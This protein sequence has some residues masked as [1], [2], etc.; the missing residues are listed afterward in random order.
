VVTRRSPAGWCRP[1]CRTPPQVSFPVA[2]PPARSPGTTAESS[3]RRRR[4]RRCGF[5]RGARRRRC[6]Q[7]IG[8]EAVDL[9]FHRGER[10]EIA[11]ALGGVG[12]LVDRLLQIGHL[13]LAHRL[14]ELALEFRRHAPDLAHVLA[15]GAQHRRQLLRADGDQRDNRDDDKLAPADIEH[16]FSNSKGR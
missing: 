14:L 11:E 7:R 12:H 13:G 5:R 3:R 8:G 2:A 4:A 16:C 9:F 15:D 10:I 1:W 6:C